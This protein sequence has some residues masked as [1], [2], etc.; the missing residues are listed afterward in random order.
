ME[1]STSTKGEITVSTDLQRY[2]FSCAKGLG[3][4][5]SSLDK[6]ALSI[7]FLAQSVTP[8]K[9]SD[10]TH[11]EQIQFA[12]ENYFIRSTSIYDRALIFAN[13]LLDLGIVDDSTSHSQMINNRH[14]KRYQLVD[15]LKHLG[16]VCREKSVER[17][18][19][20]NRPDF[21]RQF[22]ASER[23]CRS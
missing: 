18:A 20:M 10:Y 13:H 14:V 8:L 4:L 1:G 5:T 23:Y 17:N 15:H 3:V 2:I 16:K 19:I 7:E 12:I 6:A 21:Y 22:V 9:N 11:A